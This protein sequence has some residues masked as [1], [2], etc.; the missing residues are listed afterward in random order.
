MANQNLMTPLLKEPHTWVT[1]HGEIKSVLTRKPPT[2]QLVLVVPKDKQ[3]DVRTRWKAS[4]IVWSSCERNWHDKMCIW[5]QNRGMNAVCIINCFLTG[6]MTCARGRN[7]PGTANLIGSSDS[8]CE[9]LTIILLNG[10]SIKCSLSSHLLTYK[11]F[12][13][14]TSWEKFHCAVD[15][16]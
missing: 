5:V 4:A 16:V 13:F 14:Q 7:M 1:G 12:S 11:L 15:S 9:P 8:R 10:H 2:Y 3:S 6:F